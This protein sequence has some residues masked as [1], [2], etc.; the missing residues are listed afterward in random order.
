MRMGDLVQSRAIMGY[1]IGRLAEDPKFSPT[2]ELVAMV[3]WE[4]GAQTVSGKKTG[5]YVVSTLELVEL[6]D[7]TDET[8]LEGWLAS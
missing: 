2:G 1:P 3:V 6:P 7:L 5:V 4:E 8:A